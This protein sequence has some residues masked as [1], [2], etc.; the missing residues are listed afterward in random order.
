MG[1]QAPNDQN[2]RPLAQTP[3]YRFSFVWFSQASM[4]Q[5]TEGGMGRGKGKGEGAVS[6]F[7]SISQ[8]IYPAVS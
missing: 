7:S 8:G 6:D 5:Y 1:G 4:F 2:L 3:E